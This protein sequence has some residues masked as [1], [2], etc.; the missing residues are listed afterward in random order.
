MVSDTIFA[1]ID[2]LIAAI[3]HLNVRPACFPSALVCVATT[4]KLLIVL[5][6]IAVV[7]FSREPDEAET[8]AESVAGTE[9]P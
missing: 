5:S 7:V 6:S 3:R 4:H 1:L 8:L 2:P 9:A